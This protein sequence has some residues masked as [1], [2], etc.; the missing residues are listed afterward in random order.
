[1]EAPRSDPVPLPQPA[2]VDWESFYLNYRKPGYLP[3]FEIVHKLGGGMF[4]MVFKA[5]R[6]SIGKDYAI[7]FLQV[8]DAALIDL[9]RQYWQYIGSYCSLFFLE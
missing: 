1:M 5:R 3:G 2:R 6:E 4:G 7:K 9:I 8:E